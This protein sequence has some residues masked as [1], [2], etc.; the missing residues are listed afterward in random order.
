MRNP[1]QGRYFPTPINQ[2][3]TNLF[4]TAHIYITERKS[5]DIF[6]QTVDPN[7]TFKGIKRIFKR[8]KWLTFRRLG[9]HGFPTWHASKS[10]KYQSFV[11]ECLI[12]ER[13]YWRKAFVFVFL[14]SSWRF[15][16]DYVASLHILT[17]NTCLAGNSPQWRS[18]NVWR[19]GCLALQVKARHD[20]ASSLTHAAHHIN[21]RYKEKR[22]IIVVKGVAPH[23]FAHIFGNA[24][25]RRCHWFISE[26]GYVHF[27]IGMPFSNTD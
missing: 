3:N 1:L 24:R 8:V 27:L 6:L 15:A 18:P 2:N 21:A 17:G 9:I 16:P 11:H 5:V 25:G 19:H 26:N 22:L 13:Q 20:P 12:S 23:C 10:N 4:T 14:T 7:T